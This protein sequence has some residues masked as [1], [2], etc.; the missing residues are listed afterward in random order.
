MEIEKGEGR[1]RRIRGQ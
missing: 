1:F